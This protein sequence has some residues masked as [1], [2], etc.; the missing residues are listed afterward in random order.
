M[1]FLE[2]FC[3]ILQQPCAYALNEYNPFLTQSSVVSV[4]SFSLLWSWCGTFLICKDTGSLEENSV[5]REK[6]EHFLSKL[7]NIS[8]FGYCQNGA[9]SV[10]S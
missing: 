10:H 2:N 8:L 3:R 1:G 7:K 9:R 4:H 6:I 5:V